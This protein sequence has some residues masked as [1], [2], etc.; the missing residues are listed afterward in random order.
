MTTW[1]IAQLTI[2]ETQRRR[3][4]WVALLL[5]LAFLLIFALG[6]HYV[7]A[8]F[9]KAPVRPSDANLAVNFMLTAGLYA[10]NFLVIVISVITSVTAVSG[11]I[12]SHTVETLLTK[13]IRRWELVLGKWIGFAIMLL[14]YITLLCGG[15]LLFV[16]LRS[17]YAVQNLVGGL[18]LMVLQGFLLLSL[19]IAGG[20]RFS[21][22]ANGVLA[23][24]LYGL[25]FI[26]GW[27][28]QIGALL[29]NE[30][31]VN[32][33]IIASLIMPSEIVW[34][35]A[36][37]LFQPQLVNSINAV[38]PFAVASQPSD[39]MIVYAIGYM[40]ALLALALWSFTARDL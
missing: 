13:P 38:G 25:A 16:Y 29:H 18:S 26:G 20:T 2:R 31:A 7:Y 9:E 10:T 34:K 17:G 14:L 1:I 40:L 4:L 8:E 39:L 3:I 21:S 37:I 23:F 35:K 5:G 28:E 19:S 30:T 12:E 15:I 32:I 33:G 36:L 6:F 22:L 24:M 27:V 11:E